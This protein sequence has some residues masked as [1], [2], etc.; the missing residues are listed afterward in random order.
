MTDVPAYS[1]L[2][3][4][5]VGGVHSQYGLVGEQWEESE[6]SLSRLCW[7]RTPLTISVYPLSPQWHAPCP[8]GA[9]SVV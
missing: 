2:T 3:K 4:Q 1:Q 9:C 5:M 7:E 6:C 8:P